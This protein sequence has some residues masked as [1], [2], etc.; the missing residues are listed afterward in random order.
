MGG[1]HE[2]FKGTQLPSGHSF[3]APQ[4]SHVGRLGLRFPKAPT[5]TGASCKVP[6]HSSLTG[7][8]APEIVKVK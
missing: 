7:W 3:L 5:W 1:S 2:E 8:G 4:H 6:D